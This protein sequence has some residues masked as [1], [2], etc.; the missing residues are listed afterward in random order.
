MLPRYIGQ[1]MNVVFD[2]L[3]LRSVTGIEGRAIQGHKTT[4]QLRIASLVLPPIPCLYV[5]S[6]GAPLL[7]GREGFFDLFDIT[8]DNRHKK[9]VLTPLF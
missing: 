5:D 6:D 9:V 8:F 3:P 1:L 7:I 4:L 2:K